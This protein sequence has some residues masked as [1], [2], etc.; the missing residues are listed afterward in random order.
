MRRTLPA[1]VALMA[2]C[3]VRAAPAAADGIA[4][5][6]GDIDAAFAAAGRERKPLFLF[7][8]AVWCPPPCNQLKAT[9]FNR[10]DFIAR[11]RH[12][13][14]VYLDGDDA[15]AQ[16]L[17]ARLKVRAYPTMVL[18]R[19]DGTEVTRLP[20]EVD[21]E[22]YVDALNLALR[23]TR[24]VAQLVAAVE[25]GRGPPLTPADWRLLAYYAWETDR[26]VGG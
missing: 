6:A 16:A 4:W 17:A 10:Q 25:T 23:A 13:V 20:G 12:F 7:W 18:F 11:T 24:T 2:A 21:G 9:V 26:R 14:P 5:F 15:A 22:R 8:G 3:A 19:A 1:C